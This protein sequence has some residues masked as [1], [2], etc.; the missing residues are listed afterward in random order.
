MRLSSFV[1][2]SFGRP[3]FFDITGSST[4]LPHEGQRTQAKRL[5]FW[6]GTAEEN[7]L[8]NMG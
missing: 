7:H 5:A 4:A 6:G 1:A 8:G 2:R 3:S